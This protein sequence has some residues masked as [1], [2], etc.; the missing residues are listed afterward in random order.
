MIT[1]TEI[2]KLTG[3]SQATVSRVLNGNSSVNE[4]AKR[5]VLQCAK[6]HDYQPNI[7]AQSLVGNKTYLLGLVITDIGNPFFAELVKAIE[8]EAGISGYS[9]MLFNTDYD[10]EKEAQYFSILKRYQVDGVISVPIAEDKAYAE[11]LKAY[12]IPMV[13]VTMNLPN[14]D[15]V[16]VSHYDA[17]EKVAQHMLGLGYESFI[18]VGGENDR[19]EQGFFDELKRQGIDTENHYLSLAHKEPRPPKQQQRQELAEQLGKWLKTEN[20]IGG[21]GIFGN[22]DIQALKVLEILKELN[23]KV[24][25][26]IGVAGFDNTY[27]AKITSPALTSVAQPIAEIARLGMERIIE[28]IRQKPEE[29]ISYRLETRVVPRESTIKM[30][31]K[32]TKSL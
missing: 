22:N 25:E 11:K 29:C 2:A 24:P 7:L 20:N 5:K 23:I 15:S 28:L 30:K 27:L 6:E 9:L 26:D 8:K 14:V 3:V 4:E 19:K 17:G 12:D 10:K 21:I 1:M 13:S 18:F 16:Y 31:R 32:I